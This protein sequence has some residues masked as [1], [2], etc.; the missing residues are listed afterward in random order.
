MNKTEA[1]MQ[2]KGLSDLIH[3]RLE[4]LNEARRAQIKAKVAFER[5]QEHLG[6][7]IR[8]LKM[9]LAEDP[10]MSQADPRT[11]KSNEEWRGW[12]MERHIEKD[13]E[14]ISAIGEFYN[15]QLAYFESEME[16][17]QAGEE[18]AATKADALLFG[19]VLRYHAS[20]D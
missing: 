8:D 7:T 6:K 10:A 15:L 3:K 20:S 4:R 17:H 12:L 13:P 19:A 2:Y 18:L 5:S 1:E 14:Y 9:A 11:G 16:L